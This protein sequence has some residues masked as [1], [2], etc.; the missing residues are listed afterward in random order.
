VAGLAGQ[1]QQFECEPQPAGGVGDVGGDVAGVVTPGPGLCDRVE[2]RPSK[3]SLIDT[4]GTP[5]RFASSAGSTA[6]RS[7]VVRRMLSITASM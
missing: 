7:Q 6:Q 3:S 4:H 5:S 1:R 2:A